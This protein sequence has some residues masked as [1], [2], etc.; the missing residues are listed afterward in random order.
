MQPS[1]KSSQPTSSLTPFFERQGVI[2]LDGG[3]ATELER[4]GHDLNHPLWSAR[5]LMTHPNEIRAV[6]EAYLDAGADCVTAASY[7]ASIPGFLAQGLTKKQTENLLRKA[8]LLACE[9]RD[10]WVDKHR[11]SGLARLRPIV[12]AS[13]GPYGAFLADGSDYRGDY[14]VNDE[15]LYRFHAERW[16]IFAE[17]PADI[18]ACETIPSFREARVLRRLIRQT[19]DKPAWVSFSCRDGGRIS[20]GTPIAECAAFLQDCD[21]IAA[22]GV[23]CTPPQHLVNLIHSIRKAAPNKR[24]VVYPNS[25]ESYDSLSKTWHGATAATDFA[26]AGLRWREAGA[27][28]I[29]GCCR[30]TPGHIRAMRERLATADGSKMFR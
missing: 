30:T 28:L 26:D 5:L 14:D 10:D 19:P 2:I 22:I 20:D 18:I 8:V 7:Q 24:V 1:S 16:Q 11:E 9:A 23:N 13:I 27:T 21:Q 15:A 25:G 3:L 29:G 6:H 4:Q 17:T 12:A